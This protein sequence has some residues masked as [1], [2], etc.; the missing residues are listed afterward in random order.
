MT[1]IY[2]VAHYKYLNI[3][4]ADAKE[5]KHHKLR[6]STISKHTKRYG[7]K[8]ANAHAF[9]QNAKGD[10]KREK[11]IKIGMDSLKT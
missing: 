11:P 1:Q 4:R 3:A 8:C 6:C 9:S 5:R 2:K 7:D 10:A